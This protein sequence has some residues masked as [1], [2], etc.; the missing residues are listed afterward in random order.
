[1]IKTFWVSR[2]LSDFIWIL[3]KTIAPTML[4]SEVNHSPPN[5]DENNNNLLIIFNYIKIGSVI[6]NI[7]HNILTLH[8]VCCG[9][10]SDLSYFGKNICQNRSTFSVERNRHSNFMH[11]DLDNT[12][13]Q[14][15]IQTSMVN[16]FN[17]LN[18]PGL[19]KWMWVISLVKIDSFPYV[20]N[21]PKVASWVRPNLTRSNLRSHFKSGRKVPCVWY[22]SY[23]VFD[24]YW[25]MKVGCH[26]ADILT[27]LERN[28][29][30]YDP[31][32]S[33]FRY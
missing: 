4:V 28:I 6:W 32:F 24:S 25:P 10:G 11:S 8:R 18:K 20:T 3:A 2:K 22:N 29:W 26:F 12:C 15:N 9:I 23:K 17:I 14:I 33:E 27:H 30:Y 1:M 19:L 16:I 21:I 31:N 7:Y 13:P 5:F